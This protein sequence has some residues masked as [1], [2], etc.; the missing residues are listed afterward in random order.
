MKRAVLFDFGGV[1]TASP[2]EA[3]HEATT[4][5][6]V[7]PDITLDIVFGPYDR[8]TEH[9][10]H[11]LER[12]EMT[13]EDYGNQ[14]RAGLAAEGIDMDPFEVLQRMGSGGGIRADVVEE[15]RR[16]REA[17]HPTALVTN[18]IAEIREMWKALIPVD[19]LFA[20]V[21]DS[22]EVGVRKPDPR[23]FEL[24]LQAVGGVAASDA[25]FLDDYRGNIDA[26]ERLGMTGILVE[27]DHRPAFTALRDMLS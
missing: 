27:S 2:F 5:L 23:I 20:A 6:G 8:D 15:V 3:L 25:V 21:I 7:D 11:R 24:A 26:A 4:E 14:A 10:W 13:M 1:F 16:V 12:G 17:G 18:N 9:P 22:S 19:E